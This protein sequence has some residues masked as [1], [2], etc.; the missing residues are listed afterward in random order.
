[1]EFQK[2]FQNLFMQKTEVPGNLFN[3][4]LIKILYF[5][6]IPSNKLQKFYQYN[7]DMIF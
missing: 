1:M 4:D 6:G 3:K 2:K 5:I 7:I